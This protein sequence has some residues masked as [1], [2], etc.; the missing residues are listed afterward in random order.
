MPTVRLYA[1]LRKLAGTKELPISGG[2]VG[3]V[4][5]ELARQL[6]PLGPAL[7]EDGKL[8]RHLIVTVNGQNLTDPETPVTEQDIIAIFP[9]LAGG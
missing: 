2:T 7:L 1:S 3:S 4:V 8:R 9:P 5:A 6:P